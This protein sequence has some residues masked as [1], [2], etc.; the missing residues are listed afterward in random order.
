VA[1]DCEFKVGELVEYRAWYD[2][3]GAWISVENQIGIVLEIIVITDTKLKHMDDDFTIYDIK[4]YWVTEGKTE[5]VPDLLLAEYG[6][7]QVEF[8]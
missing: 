6:H 7:E 8:I 4:V 3:E 1:N 2:G 5:I